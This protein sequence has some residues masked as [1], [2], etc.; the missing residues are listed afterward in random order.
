MSFSCDKSYKLQLNRSV[1]LAAYFTLIAS[2]TFMDI[3]GQKTTNEP[4]LTR[5]FSLY[6]NMKSLIFS[7]PIEDSLS[8]IFGLKVISMMWIVIAHHFLLSFYMPSFNSASK[9]DVGFYCTFKVV[10]TSKK[11][12]SF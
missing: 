9:F 3:R 4:S 2:C 10:F 11:C 12:F 7:R 1:F 8:C 6:S 5:A